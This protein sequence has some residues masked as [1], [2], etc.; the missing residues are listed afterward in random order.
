MQASV[1]QDHDVEDL[2]RIFNDLFKE[3]YNTILVRGE[4]EPI[5]LP[6]D[7]EHPYNRLVFAHGYFSSALHE[8][9]HWCIA[10]KR[11]RTLVDFGYWYQPDGRTAAQQTAFLKVEVKPQALEWAFSVAAGHKFNFSADNLDGQA[12]DM[13]LFKEAVHQQIMAWLEEGF[14]ARARHFLKAL[15]DFYGTPE[16]SKAW[17]W[18]T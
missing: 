9:A 17:T 5:Y 16:P 11:R 7:E 18:W 1:Q 2:I 10:G 8:I 3:K 15:H 4:D 12:T 13:T 6:A 14:P